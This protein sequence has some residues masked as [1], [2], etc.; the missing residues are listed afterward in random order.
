[1]QLYEGAEPDVS[2]LGYVDVFG[3]SKATLHNPT[4]SLPRLSE[5]KLF[6]RDEIFHPFL[7]IP[8]FLL[9]QRKLKLL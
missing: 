4:R 7:P 5:C 3:V 6:C 1:M 2:Y 8:V 9:V